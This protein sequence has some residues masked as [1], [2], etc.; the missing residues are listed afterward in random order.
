MKLTDFLNNV[1]RPVAYYP[2]LR[3]V[4]G[5]TN[6]T[7]LLCQ[8]MYWRGKEA[9]GDGWL[10][11]T[12]DEIEKE[13]GLSYGEQKTAR[14]DLISAG[15]L[16]EHY[17]RLDHQ[18]RFK[19]DLDALNEKWEVEETNIPESG[20]P[21]FG[22]E[23]KPHSLNES[24]NT[25]ENTM[26]AEAVSKIIQE[27]DKE[28]DTVLGFEKLAQEAEQKGAWRGREYFVG[29]EYLKYADWWH[30]KTGLHMY[31]TKGKAKFDKGWQKAFKEL[32]ENDVTI[33][34]LDIAWESTKWKHPLSSPMQIVNEAKAVQA[35]PKAET[36]R[37]E[38]PEGKGFYV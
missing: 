11:K 21:K 20:K 4:T 37:N 16:E 7:I 14:R 3:R 31:G 26:P 9:S 36:L 30:T 12:A 17:A 2:K 6:A 15:L 32:W 34:S 38:Q 18:M 13:T 24:E 19:L 8:F 25:A 29:S 1:G 35:A 23:Q 27:A 28:V 5:S 22:N 10:Y 33:A